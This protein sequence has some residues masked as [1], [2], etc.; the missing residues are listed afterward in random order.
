MIEAT[1]L[2]H[3]GIQL[4]YG[5]NILDE[6]N[7]WMALIMPFGLKIKLAEA[8][9]D[10]FKEHFNLITIESRLILADPDRKI[11]SGEL[12]LENHV[13]DLMT[14]LKKHDVE[15]ATLIGYCSGAGIALAAANEHKQNFDNL[16]LVSGEYTLMEDSDCITP[17]G[18]DIDSLLSMAS[19]DEQ[20]A[21]LVFDKI[22]NSLS[23]VD[24]SRP[25]GLDLPFSQYEYL[26][27]YGVNYLSYRETDFRSL[28]STVSH[29]TLLISGAK[30]AQ[31]NIQSTQTICDLIDNS[32]ILIDPKGDHYE[33]LRPES[34]L[35]V[36]IWNH[37]SMA[38][39]D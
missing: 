3:D 14:V 25:A 20:K 39:I 22:K 4:N 36:E 29:N 12:S 7:P 32:E 16:I 30:D 19:I 6:D 10:F 31:T 26:H 23:K 5:Y 17:F 38:C 28:A 24:E 35:M 8:F 37:M 1:T 13:A 2:S 15:Q 34:N 21:K 9:F 33:I 11:K 27:R 18:R